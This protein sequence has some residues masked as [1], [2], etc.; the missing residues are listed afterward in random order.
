[1]EFYFIIFLFHAS[2]RSELIKFENT[3]NSLNACVKKCIDPIYKK[4][5]TIEM[6]KANIKCIRNDFQ[7]KQ[8]T[9]RKI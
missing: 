5:V 1:M 7:N 2:F 9:K 8:K 6:N 3:L 4:Q